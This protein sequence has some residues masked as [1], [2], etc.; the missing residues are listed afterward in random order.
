MRITTW[1]VNGIRAVMKKEFDESVIKIGADM[2]CLQET[3]A[4][5][6]EVDA[7]LKHYAG[8]YEIFR[9]SAERKGYSGTAILT[10][11]KPLNVTYGLNLPEFD[12]EGRVVTAEYDDFFL[13]TVYT[14]NGGEGL[15]RLDF[16]EQWNKVFQEYLERLEHTKPV[17]SCGDFNVAHRPID[18]KNPESNY[19]K[20]AGYTQV[21]IDGMDNLLGVGFVDVFRHLNPDKVE[22]TYWSYR[23]N[24]RARNAGWRID[25]FIIS[26]KLIDKVK[27]IT[28]HPEIYGSDH[29]PV[30]LD[31]EL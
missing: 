5:V 31:M 19:N 1:N 3:K 6:D 9:N 21:E 11:Q 27:D 25:Y 12:T 15:K 13:V 7:A 14:P 10:N 8:K 16:K 28:I 18:L 20:T 30:S 2:L 26:P 17:I 29:C 23:F 4:Q 24:A 22:Y